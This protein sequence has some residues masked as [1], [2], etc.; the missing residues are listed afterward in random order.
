[1]EKEIN[2]YMLKKR[3]VIIA[4]SPELFEE[5]QD[6]HLFNNLDDLFAKFVIEYLNIGD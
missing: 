4:V 2:K 1:M 3:K 6:K 5:M